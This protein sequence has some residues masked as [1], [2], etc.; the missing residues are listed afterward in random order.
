MT[1]CVA[2]RFGKSNRRGE[3]GDTPLYVGFDFVTSLKLW[4]F[5]GF[6][7]LFSGSDDGSVGKGGGVYA[8]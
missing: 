5:F 8:G 3:T 7:R 2:G 6:G 1:R 4:G